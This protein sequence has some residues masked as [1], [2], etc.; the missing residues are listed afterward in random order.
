MGSFGNPFAHGNAQ[1]SG[2]KNLR[3][4]P[5]QVALASMYEGSSFDVEFHRFDITQFWGH[6]HPQ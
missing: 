4:T 5:S 2:A 6:E 3:P 1:H